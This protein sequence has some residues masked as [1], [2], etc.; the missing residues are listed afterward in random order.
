MTGRP[1][2]TDRRR[3]QSTSLAGAMTSS[4]ATPVGASSKIAGAQL[5]ERGADAEQLVLG[6]VG[7]GDRLTVDG[8]VG[9][10]ARR[11][12]AER[13]RRDGLLHDGA[14]RRDV[15]GAGRL[16]AR[17]ALAHDVGPHRAVG[18]LRADVDGEAATVQSVEI[19]GEALPVPRHALGQGG[20]GD[21]LDPF[22]EPDEPV[23]AVGTGRREADAAVA[24][25]D[26]RH[27]VPRAGSEHL[28]PG[29][30]AVVVGVDVD[31][32]R[33]H[34]RAVGVDRWRRLHPVE[35]A[36]GGDAP[37][38]D[39]HVRGACGCSRAVDDG[40]GSNHEVVHGLP[41]V[42]GLHGGIGS[43]P[44]QASHLAVAGAGHRCRS[45]MPGT[46]AGRTLPHDSRLMAHG[47]A[48]WRPGPD[49]GGMDW[50]KWNTSSG[51]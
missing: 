27:A 3:I 44:A 9:D 12:E 43:F 21:V 23:V 37:V 1:M 47:D 31:P 34:E 5:A 17:A 10:G 39:R 40:S 15:L 45:P 7:P 28:V 25:D 20:P 8:A 6:R 18:D 49:G 19:L 26:G 42:S 2:A 41:P 32:A 4:P 29:G 48:A 33:C 11:G 24:G 13:A 30:L 22:H 46:P 36:N 14:H 35:R 16:V 50:A 38:V 51:S